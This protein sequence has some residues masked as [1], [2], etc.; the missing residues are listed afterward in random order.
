MWAWYTAETDP[1]PCTYTRAGPSPGTE[2][3]RRE[4]RH[5]LAGPAQ[6]DITD[7]NRWFTVLAFLR[8]LDDAAA[9][10]TALRRRMAFLEQP[11]SFF[12]D[13]DRPLRAEE[14]GDPFRRGILTIARATSRAELSWLR[15]TLDSLDG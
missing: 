7:E 10:A 12:Y 4:L 11:A 13:G 3:G 5:R 9:Q 2:E 15:K 8:H 1:S 14:L 6:R